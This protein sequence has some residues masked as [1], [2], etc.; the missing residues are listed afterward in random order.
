MT[1][2][3]STNPKPRVTTLVFD[4]TIVV[5]NKKHRSKWWS[6]QCLGCSR[7][8]RRK[9]GTCKHE[10]LVLAAVSPKLK[11]RTRIEPYHE[12]RTLP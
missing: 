11:S 2:P 6:I 10:R 9:D 5:L 3:Q 8:R 12:L 7:Y 1:T 4:R